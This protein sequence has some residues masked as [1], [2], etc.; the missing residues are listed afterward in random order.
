MC[1]HVGS[2]HPKELLQNLNGMLINS[3]Y[4]LDYPRLLPPTF[5]NVG[6][7]QI[8]NSKPLPKNIERFF[9][10]SGEHGVVLFTMGFIFN[11]QI[12]PKS[13]M[14]AFM[15]A[16]KRLPQKFLVKFDGPLENIPDNVKI[17]D[18]I[19][20]QDVL[21]HPKTRLFLTHCGLHGV[22]E[23]I[24]FGVPMV[25]MPIFTGKALHLHQFN[26]YGNNKT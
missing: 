9:E 12:V 16:F 26:L 11:P 7:L 3:D 5:I 20:Q 19:P 25:G 2:P 14:N 1:F 8:R 23:A 10:S 18:F 17:L 4:A 24:H 13:L 6:G 15:S 21:A 22:M